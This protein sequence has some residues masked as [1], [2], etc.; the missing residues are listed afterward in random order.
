MWR[1]ILTVFLVSCSGPAFSSADD[2]PPSNSP[3]TSAGLASPVT[4]SDAGGAESAS[5]PP[6]SGE[7]DGGAQ[8]DHD[9]PDGVVVLDAS[10]PCTEHPN[11]NERAPECFDWARHM[12]PA[13]L[14]GC[15][16]HETHGCAVAVVNPYGNLVCAP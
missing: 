5:L 13:A 16:S 3:E 10:P 8:G 9:L 11:E 15:C 12:N 4:P 7:F 14:Y 1:L 6:I 2:A